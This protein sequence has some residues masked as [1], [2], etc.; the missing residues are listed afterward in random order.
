VN[1]INIFLVATIVC[2]T[3]ACSLKKA[4]IDNSIK[5]YFDSAQVDGCFTMMDNATGAITVY[6]IKYDTTRFT[7]AGSFNLV[8]SL[9]G[10]ENGAIVNEDAQISFKGEN[11]ADTTW[12]KDVNLKQALANNVYP[13]FKTIVNKIGKDTL[14]HW[15]DTLGYGNKQLGKSIDSAW[16]NNS[17]KVSPDEQVGFVKRLYFDQLPF[18]KSTQQ[19]LRS[20]LLKEANTN[21]K[22]SYLV[23]QGQDDKYGN[24]AWLT[25]YIEENRHVYFFATILVNASNGAGL[26]DKALNISKRI[27][28]H[29]NF[30]QGKK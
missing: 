3:Q 8:T 14:Q 30:F 26:E 24:I 2:L 18:R 10:L 9:V 15:I 20:L 25:G 19:N 17:I 27:L 7:A 29:Y 1:K 16:L 12:N 23:S 22:L 5:P 28:T 21:F 4:K 13:Y 11:F 6:N